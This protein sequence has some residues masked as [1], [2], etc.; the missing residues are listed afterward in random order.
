M[1]PLRGRCRLF[2]CRKGFYVEQPT[3]IT[4]DS[5]AI[6]DESEPLTGED[7]QA[8][9]ENA[10]F[11]EK[12]DALD[13]ILDSENVPIDEAPMPLPTP[14]EEESLLPEPAQEATET[15]PVV[16]VP[17]LVGCH[18]TYARPDGN[19]VTLIACTVISGTKDM[20]R[21]SVEPSPGKTGFEVDA[22]HSDELHPGSW[23]MAR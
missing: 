16:P 19:C 17:S 21:L 23:R 3:E 2:Y 22:S 9:D 8:S 20:A 1:L 6:S 18:G 15:L 14:L 12:V 11:I 10:T 7:T 4:P 5:P 13:A